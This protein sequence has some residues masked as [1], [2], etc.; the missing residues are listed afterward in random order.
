MPIEVA[1]LGQNWNRERRK[2]QLR[3]FEPVDV[4]V[5]DPKAPGNIGQDRGVE[6]LQNTAR[7]FNER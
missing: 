1:Q 5:M 3:R 4:R 6:P 2:H 7:D